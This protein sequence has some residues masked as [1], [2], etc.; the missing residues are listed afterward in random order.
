MGRRLEIYCDGGCR[1][2]Q[3][4][5]NV[6]GWGALLVWDGVEKRIHG[7]EANT[8]NNKMELLAAIEG[9]RAERDKTVPTDV[10]VDSAYV[11]GG[12]TKWIDG[13]MRNGW[14]TAKKEPVANKE[15]WLAL[16]AERDKFSDIT[17]HKVKGHADNEGNN[18]ADALANLGMDEIEGKAAC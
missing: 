7:G 5:V 14:K 2:N 11:L 9:L 18:I 12:I 17:F 3:Q 1:G 15:L 13:W 8:T 6:G 4:D 16:L 10:Y